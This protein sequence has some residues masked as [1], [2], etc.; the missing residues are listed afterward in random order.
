MGDSNLMQLEKE[1][2]ELG[3]EELT[4]EQQNALADYSTSPNCT[5]EEAE[6]IINNLT[7]F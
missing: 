6:K 2:E 1:L 4:I 7:K 3:Y 5:V